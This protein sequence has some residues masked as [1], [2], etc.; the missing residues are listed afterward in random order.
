MEEDLSENDTPR[1]RTSR[2]AAEKSKTKMTKMLHEA[3]KDDKPDITMEDSDNDESWKPTEADKQSEKDEKGEN[4]EAREECRE[5]QVYNVGKRGRTSS[6]VRNKPSNKSPHSLIGT[7]TQVVLSGGP[8]SNGDFVSLKTDTGRE[9]APLWRYD[10]YGTM[11]KYNSLQSQA[12]NYLHKSANIFNGYI[13]SDRDKFDSVAVKYVHA[14]STAYT[15]KILMSDKQGANTNG[16][17]IGVLPAKTFSAEVSATRGQVFKDTSKMQEPFEVYIQALI[18]HCLDPNFLVEVIADKDTFFLDNIEKIEL[19][20]KSKRDRAMQEA[21]WPQKFMQAMTTWPKLMQTEVGSKNSKCG[22]CDAKYTSIELKLSGK[23]YKQDNLKEEEKGIL[24][25]AGEF[26]I[27]SK[28]KVLSAIFHQLYHYKHILLITCE[29]MINKRKKEEPSMESA[30]I[31]TELL[32]NTS[33]LDEQ[34]KN[35][36]E[37]WAD[38]ETYT[39][40]S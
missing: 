16:G 23:P 9:N 30:T 19:L 36:Q 28:C 10:C 2:K 5:L 25:G 38:A 14:D 7:E 4:E 24:A 18:S 31:L 27:C 3:S 1:R 35:V 40:P 11:Q 37:R 34:F 22:A 17:M 12:G 21:K 6:T 8:L 26:L 20:S 15:V 39:R 33:W 29:E 32:A 13:A